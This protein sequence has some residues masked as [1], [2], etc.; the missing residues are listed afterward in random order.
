MPGYP[1][2]MR[3][4]YRRPQWRDVGDYTRQLNDE[5][6]KPTR[7]RSPTQR[8]STSIPNRLAL[9]RVLENKTCSPMSLHDF[10]M[11]L[12]HVE[13]SSENLEF[14]LW[15][16]NYE[17]NAPKT[18]I[19]DIAEAPGD[20]VPLPPGSAARPETQTS[21]VS[22]TSTT[23]AAKESISSISDSIMKAQPPCARLARPGVKWTDLFLDRPAEATTCTSERSLIKN[24]A[25]CV[26]R[27]TC[28]I[29]FNDEEKGA[30]AMPLAFTSQRAEERAEL[31]AAIARFLVPGAEK[32]LNISH[33]LRQ[34]T[35]N[36]LQESGDPRHLKPVVDHI[37]EVM[38][39]CSHRN[40]VALGVATG[41]YETICV[42]NL[43]GIM[44]VIGGFLLVLLRALYPHIGY[45]GNVFD[46]A[47]NV[48]KTAPTMGEV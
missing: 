32:E 9:E 37:Y 23:I 25:P 19:E 7:S 35:L 48:E 16:K 29:D 28:P 43:I 36:K 26:R 12:Q 38:K 1:D 17:A 31:D 11:Y 34:R 44:C 13:H 21:G 18:T 8:Q 46:H 47:V 6:I 33:L 27:G 41:S 10:Y 4:W 42:G 39:N 24:P 3:I 20:D 22:S 30:P 40:F 15:Y 5:D 14:Y 45:P 2:W